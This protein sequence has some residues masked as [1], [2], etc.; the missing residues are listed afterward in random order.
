[1]NSEINCALLNKIQKDFGLSST[2]YSE[3][4]QM[5]TVPNDWEETKIKNHKGLDINM[6]FRT[7]ANPKAVILVSQGRAQYC[8]EWIEFSSHMVSEGYTFVTYDPQGQGLSYSLT[9]SRKHHIDNYYMTEVLD[10]ASVVNAIKQDDTLGKLPLYGV[11]HS[12]GGNTI[13][14]YLAEFPNAK[15]D[16]RGVAQIAPMMGLQYP[17]PFLRKISPYAPSLF[18][19][20]G[21]GKSYAPKQGAFS[22][23]RYTTHMGKISNDPASRAVQYYWFNEKPE[24][25]CHGPTWGFVNEAQKA[26]NYLE[27]PTNNTAEYID[28]PTFW[29]LGEQE[30]ILDNNAAIRFHERMLDGDN[31]SEAKTYDGA[32]HQVHMERSTTKTAFYSDLKRHIRKSLSL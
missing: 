29:A 26:C 9:K 11:G 20:I 18:S 19:S 24:T 23:E 30:Q 28:T 10:L 8:R 5:V 12:K 27:K 1:M 6:A 17:S 4:T 25:I 14:R 31:Q 3:L 22:F 7:R 21:F 32:Q 16:F 15:N 2:Q 13:M